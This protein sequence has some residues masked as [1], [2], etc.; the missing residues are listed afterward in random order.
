MI[1]LK[2]TSL[3]QRVLNFLLVICPDHHP[4]EEGGHN[5]PQDLTLQGCR[6]T[7]NLK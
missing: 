7:S 5:H 6:V 3:F 2:K 1:S 4:I